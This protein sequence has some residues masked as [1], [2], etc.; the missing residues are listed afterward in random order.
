MLRLKGLN[1]DRFDVRQVLK[2]DSQFGKATPNVS[3]TAQAAKEYLIPL[4]DDQVIVT[5]GFVG[6]DE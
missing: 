5:Q 6:S 2:T 1:A 4:L 3:A